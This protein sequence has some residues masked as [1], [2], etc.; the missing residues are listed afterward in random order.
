[1]RPLLIF[2]AFAQSHSQFKLEK[3]SKLL[4]SLDTSRAG[5]SKPAKKIN[6]KKP[7]NFVFVQVHSFQDRFSSNLGRA[8]SHLCV[9]ISAEAPTPQNRTN[10]WGKKPKIS[11]M[12]KPLQ[13]RRWSRAGARDYSSPA[14]RGCRDSLRLRL[15]PLAA[16]TPGGDTGR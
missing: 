8:A 15:L 3:P 5:H 2:D 9:T 4:H 6:T 16:V 14:I 13:E 11:E 12:L 1:M 10:N 7:A